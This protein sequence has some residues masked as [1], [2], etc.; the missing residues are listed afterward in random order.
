MLDC[1]TMQRNLRPSHCCLHWARLF[2]PPKQS[3]P[4]CNLRRHLPRLQ[5]Q[6]G[7]IAHLHDVQKS[8]LFPGVS[9]RAAVC[10]TIA[11][12]R[13]GTNPWMETPSRERDENEY[14]QNQWSGH[15]PNRVL[16]KDAQELLAD[17]E[18]LCVPPLRKRSES[19]FKTTAH[20]LPKSSIPANSP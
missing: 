14:S 5:R 4:A 15:G 1:W 6:G 9:E 12:K 13:L 17:R 2:R 11:G 20:Y 19:C 8:L 7:E 18:N 16:H 10:R 3:V